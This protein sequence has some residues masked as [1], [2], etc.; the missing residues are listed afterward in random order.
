M[1]VCD[2]NE[3]TNLI[4]NPCRRDC[5]FAQNKVTWIKRICVPIAIQNQPAGV[6]YNAI[7]CAT[8]L[9]TNNFLGVTIPN[10]DVG[11][12]GVCPNDPNMSVAAYCHILAFPKCYNWVNGCIEKCDGEN[13]NTYCYVERRYC[14]KDNVCTMCQVQICEDQETTPCTPNCT[15]VECGNLSYNACCP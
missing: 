6:I 14:V 2:Q 10:C 5:D 13:C 7:I 1:E 9:C 3:T 12:G 15:T 11:S 4:V 8:D